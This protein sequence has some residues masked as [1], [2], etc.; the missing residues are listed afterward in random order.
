MPTEGSQDHVGNAKRL[1]VD[2]SLVIEDGDR[3]LV[4]MEVSKMDHSSG[5]VKLTPRQYRIL[6][7]YARNH[8]R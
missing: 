2:V 4:H 1:P 8:S 5:M 7:D 6:R 3:Q